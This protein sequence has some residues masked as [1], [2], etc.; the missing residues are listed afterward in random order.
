MAFFMIF[1]M[2]AW[3]RVRACIS[4]GRGYDMIGIRKY[5]RE[6]KRKTKKK[7]TS[8]HKRPIDSVGWVAWFNAHTHAWQS[9]IL[10][11]FCSLLFVI[12][13]IGLEVSN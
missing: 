8:H 11:S 5:T 12:S 13:V 1:V 10:H 9:D 3:L 7:K 6:E 4:G 2:V